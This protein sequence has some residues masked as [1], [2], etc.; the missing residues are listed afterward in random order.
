MAD[1]IKEIETEYAGYLFRSRLEARW[2]V[3]FD[4]LDIKWQY[5]T[6]GFENQYGDRYLPDFFFPE[7]RTWVEVKGDKDALVRDHAKM[8]RLLDHGGVLPGFENSGLAETNRGLLLL[9][10]IP[11]PADDGITVHPLIQHYKGLHKTWAHF[12]RGVLYPISFGSGGYLL[13][14][15][16][17]DGIDAHA[18]AW[19]IEHVFVQT[20]LFWPLVADAYAAARHARFEHGQSGASRKR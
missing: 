8:V 14:V 4:A 18:D 9:G 12:T 1:Q 20:R 5:E 19:R 10:E 13:E 17:D 7:T 6:E 11:N 16:D 3:F 2:A 15:E